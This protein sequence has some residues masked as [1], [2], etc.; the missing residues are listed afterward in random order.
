MG[1]SDLQKM[2]YIDKKACQLECDSH[3]SE[4]FV[5]YSVVPKK[6]E[7]IPGDRVIVENSVYTLSNVASEDILYKSAVNKLTFDELNA[8]INHILK[9][10]K[11]IK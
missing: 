1:G 4:E 9:K 10:Y 2:A 8:V 7:I 11:V 6:G 5:S 3:K